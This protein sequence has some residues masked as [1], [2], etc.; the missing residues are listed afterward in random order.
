MAQDFMTKVAMFFAGMGAIDFALTKY[1][2]IS[3][4]ITNMIPV[5]YRSYSWALL[6]I[7]GVAG[8]YT[9]YKAFSK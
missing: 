5:A 1:F 8:A 2:S 3:T 9:I 6:V 4:F 7:Y